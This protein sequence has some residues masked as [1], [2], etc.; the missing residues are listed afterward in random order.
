M[1]SPNENPKDIQ[2]N[3]ANPTNADTLK[4]PVVNKEGIPTSGAS[5]TSAAPADIIPK[6]QVRKDVF[7]ICQPET[8]ISKLCTDYLSKQGLN[9]IYLNDQ[10]HTNQTLEQNCLTYPNVSFA[11]IIL[12]GEEF[13]Y[14][15]TK[16]PADA[17]LKAP[18][19]LVFALGFFLAKFG[20]QNVFVLYQEQKKLL[21]ADTIPSRHLYIIG[22]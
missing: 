19:N 14:S 9:L 1:A 3:S 11:V 13:V 18:Q 10:K 15:K 22:F 6:P 5:E 2:Q 17:K 16:K 7:V 12:T 21:I 8:K 20:R 4:E